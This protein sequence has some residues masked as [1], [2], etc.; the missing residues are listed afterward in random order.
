[1]HDPRAVGGRD[2]ARA[3]LRRSRADL[4]MAGVLL[5]VGLGVAIGVVATKSANATGLLDLRIYRDAARGIGSGALYD[6]EDPRF[7]LG[8]T[9]PPFAA[10][11]FAALGPIPRHALEYAW[12]IVG[13][14]SWLVLL[15]CLWRR[16]VRDRAPQWARDFPTATVTGIWLISLFGAPIWIALNQGQI[17]IFLWV[18][19]TADV[20]LT[21]DD[22]RGSGALTGLAAATKVLPLVAIPLYWIGDRAS[23]ARRALLGF[24]AAT[25][26]GAVLLPSESRRYWGEL[27]WGT[28]VGE[29]ADARN[30]SLLG[31]LAR[32][33]GEGRSTTISAVVLGL[34]VFVL[35]AIAF[36]AAVQRRAPLAATLVLG[37]TMSLLSPITW[38]HHLVFLSLLLLFPL[39]SW[40]DHPAGSAVALAIVVVVLVDPLG[41]GN[42]D[43]ALSSSLRA[44]VML[45]ILVFNDRLVALERP[46]GRQR[47]QQPSRR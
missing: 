8:F 34:G 25:L 46:Q 2:T 5:L 37:S 38:T 45:A 12:S 22:R 23:A 39:L 31:V 47:L 21:I 10:V 32:A 43:A 11:L 27:L 33:F 44:L 41:A 9:Y 40:R 16:C 18:A 7:G 36:R 1:M 15:W 30:D 4:A 26:L 42:A 13:A 3:H 20:V 35:G 24:A 14:S 19:L 6:Y 29:R 17:G 28:R